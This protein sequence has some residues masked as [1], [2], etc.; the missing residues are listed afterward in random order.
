MMRERFLPSSAG[1]FMSLYFPIFVDL[2]SKNVLFIGGGRITV[3]RIISIYEFAGSVTVVSPE[4]EPEIIKRADAG[5]IR[6]IRKR[7]DETDLDDADIV[8]VNTGH[9]GTDIRIAG[10]CRRR[11]LPVNVAS[12]QTLC[13]FYFPGIIKKDSVVVGVT[14]SGE[15]HH[16]AADVTARIREL[17]K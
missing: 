13:D 17:L 10:M 15:D 8:L 4:A 12:D 3:R 16:K 2:S 6:Y 1:G 7:F 5:Y 14:A 9:Q 11:H